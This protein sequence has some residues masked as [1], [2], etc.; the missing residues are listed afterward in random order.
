MIEWY[1]ELNAH[2]GHEYDFLS[3]LI[4]AYEALFF[5]FSNYSRTKHL[6]IQPNVSTTCFPAAENDTQNFLSVDPLS[7]KEETLVAQR[8]IS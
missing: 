7:F 4:L 2:E 3:C 5:L 6:N 1:D 8:N